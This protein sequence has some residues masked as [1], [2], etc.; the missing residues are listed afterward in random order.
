MS[1][2]LLG[3]QNWLT[4]PAAADPNFYG[5]S[6]T[7]LN[8]YRNQL[9]QQATARAYQQAFD[10]TTGQVDPSK[11]NA[12][13]TQGAG[14]W[15]AG[16]AMQ[17][18][19]QAQAAQGQGQQEAL[20]AH[21]ARMSS[22][23]GL[24][25]GM[26]AKG[27]PIGISDVTSALNQAHLSPG[28]ATQISADANQTSGGNPDFDYSGWVKNHM[29]ANL[30]AQEQV[31]RVT[32]KMQFQQAGNRIV[33]VD[34]NPNTNPN[35]ATIGVGQSPGTQGDTVTIQYPDGHTEQKTRDQ[36]PAVLGGN[37]GAQVVPG[38]GGGDPIAGLPKNQALPA[39]V[40]RESGGQNVPTRILGPDGKPAS[41]ASG[42]YQ[43]L[44]TTWQEGAKL[45]GIKNPPPR[46]MDASR[47]DQDAAASALYDQHGYQP[48]AASGG[49]GG[50]GGGGAAPA[51]YRVAGNA[52][53][54][55]PAS[56]GTG[57]SG[58]WDTGTGG[59]A[60]ARLTLP[61][62][63][64]IPSV[65]LPGP[66][67]AGAGPLPGGNWGTPGGGFRPAPA[68]APAPPP[69]APV[70]TPPA[71]V[72][73]PQPP[74]PRAGVSP[75]PGYATTVEGHAK[76]SVD[77]AN[78]MHANASASPQRQA[79]LADMDATNKQINTGP[80]TEAATKWSAFANQLPLNIGTVIPGMSR[81]QVAGAEGFAK[82]A[83]TFRQMQAGGIAGT[84]TNDKFASALASNPHMALSTLGNQGMI[85]LLQGN[86][87]AVQA[88]DQAWSAASTA[89]PGLDYQQWETNFNKTFDP[90]VFWWS[91]MTRPEQQR[92]MSGMDDPAQKTLLGHLKQA[93]SSG[94]ITRPG[95]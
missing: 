64:E 62:S 65:P 14:A 36:V 79:L 49:G 10:P 4:Q 45:A 89:N 21:R 38:A 66:R 17:Q 42:Y 83:E 50:G 69:A 60:P 5:N 56:G 41:T 9:A 39:I 87:D 53:V 67:A 52:P 68:T 29:T 47:A 76:A 30:S 72:V 8:N 51:P 11:F 85:H 88:K 58:T 15:N 78:A 27:G 46:A 35:P 24:M 23:L 40:A 74:A 48:W 95:G 32:P 37:P 94:I 33:P 25:N 31:D 93:E 84:L 44:D 55:P 18:Q 86:E 19:G 92:L 77:M 59:T 73:A 43:M 16:P 22:M 75:P 12:L 91:R 80:A 2:T 13:V 26:V 63:V 82:L 70:V 7:N 28:E 57:D 6:L 20:A 81:E 61:S 3:P 34:M 1:T 90:R 71:P 54:A